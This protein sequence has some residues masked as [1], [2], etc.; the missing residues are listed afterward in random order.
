MSCRACY[1]KSM[2][3]AIAGYGVEGRTNYAYFSQKYPG[4]E[5][6]IVDERGAL[7]DAPEGVE[8]LLGEGAFENL[9]G[10]DMVV[11]TAGLP[12]RKIKTAGVV[13]SATNEFFARCAEKGVPIIGVTGTKGK[14]TTCSLIASI[15][16]AAGKT[17]HL[18]GNIGVPALDVLP[19]LQPN[20]VVV[21]ELSSFQLWDAEKSPHI[22]VVL[23]VEPDHLDAHAS[24]DEYVMAKSNIAAHQTASDVVIYHPTNEFSRRIAERSAGEKQ[25]YATKEDGGVYVR[26]GAFYMLEDAICRVDTLHIAGVHNQENACAAISAVKKFL[27]GVTN[28]QIA[29]GL[30]AFDGLPH[31]LKFA[32]EKNGVKY[33]DDSIATTPG[34]ALAAIRAFD[35]PK[36]LLLGGRDKGGDYRELFEVCRTQDVQV[37]AYGENRQ[38]LQDMM[39]QFGVNYVVESGDIR[40]VVRTASSLAKPGSVVILS[41]AASSFDMFKNYA[42]R[43]EQFIRAIKEAP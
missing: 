21:Y 12:P 8:T 11:R 26:N 36:V 41:P 5:V 18:V 29:E 20:D 10:F 35:Q 32:A 22:A 24:F 13:T 37:V 16:R 39:N 7:S 17:V 14:G 23:M 4:A 31:R 43:G 3:I 2:R 42:D 33:Y 19:Q 27:P 34:S 9:Q 15:L 25:R 28:Q 1:D 30:S 6:V 38:K 40:A